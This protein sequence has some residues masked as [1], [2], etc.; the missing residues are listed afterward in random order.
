MALINVAIKFGDEYFCFGI[1]FS[2]I[3]FS[4]F[5]STFFINIFF[6]NFCSKIFFLKFFVI[7]FPKIFFPTFF[8]NF[9]F[10]GFTLDTSPFIESK[11]TLCICV[12]KNMIS[13]RSKLDFN[14]VDQTWTHITE[15]IFLTSCKKF[16]IFSFI[17]FEKRRLAQGCRL[18]HT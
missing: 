13:K 4:N 14:F 11:R 9:F 2:T 6:Q 3:Y 17:L 5:F 18:S 15:I 12:M 8:Q 16:K 7:C 1:Y 10:E